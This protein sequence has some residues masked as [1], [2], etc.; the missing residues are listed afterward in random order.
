MSTIAPSTRYRVSVGWDRDRAWWYDVW[1][2][3]A[4]GHFAYRVDSGR[5]YSVKS[6]AERAASQAI[7]DDRKTRSSLETYEVPLDEEQ[8]G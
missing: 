6:R 1:T 4:L 7:A 8:A 5:G 3:T 2:V